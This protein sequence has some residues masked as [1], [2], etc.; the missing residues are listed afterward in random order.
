MA[1]T[2]VNIRM[3]SD[4]KTQFEAFCTDMGMTMTTAFTVFA[5]KKQYANIA[6]L[7]KSAPKYRTP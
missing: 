2:N 6:F 3:D 4:L 5:K 7:L 1:Q